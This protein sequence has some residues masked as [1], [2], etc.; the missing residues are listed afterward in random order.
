MEAKNLKNSSSSRSPARKETRADQGPKRYACRYCPL[1][2]S[3]AMAL[4]GHQNGHKSV[5]A[6]TKKPETPVPPPQPCGFCDQWRNLALDQMTNNFRPREP[7]QLA[8]PSPPMRLRNFLGG[9]SAEEKTPEA[10]AGRVNVI[11]VEDDEDDVPEL[12]LDLK[13]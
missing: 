11:N 1:T 5:R 4:G 7:H 13:L 8:V 9:S 2:F 10:S 3:T 6:S 12:D